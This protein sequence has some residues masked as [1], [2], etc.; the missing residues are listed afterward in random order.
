LGNVA[1]LASVALIYLLGAIEKSLG[2]WAAM[3]LDYSTHTAVCVAIIVS[4]W[5]I[6]RRAR[7]PATLIGLLYAGL[8][9]YQKYHSVGDIATTA[10]IIV[11]SSYLVCAAAAKLRRLKTT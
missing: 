8:M 11:G 2:L 1:T 6:D 3:G 10:A 5:W 9:L 4:L 7:I